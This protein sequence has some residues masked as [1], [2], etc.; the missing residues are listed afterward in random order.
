MDSPDVDR[1]RLPARI[2]SDGSLR[3]QLRPGQWTIAIEA[4]AAAVAAE[5][6]ADYGK[7]W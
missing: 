5:L 4:R 6:G 1:G 2:E 3:V 7:R